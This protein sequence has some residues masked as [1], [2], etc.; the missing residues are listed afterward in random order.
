MT[1]EQPF[2]DQPK[3][4]FCEP[5]ASVSMAAIFKTLKRRRRQLEIVIMTSLVVLVAV[6]FLIPSTYTAT[7]SFIPPTSNNGGLSSL[8]NQL[9]AV[10]VSAALGA[11]K[12]NG[13][14]YVGILGSHI[15]A[16]RLV[17]RFSLM[18]V[19]DVKKESRAVKRL[20]S[21]SSFEV[22]VRDGIVTI[23]VTDRSATRARDLAN[24]YL[25]ELRRVTGQLALSE[26]AQRR[27]FFEQQLA[28]EK[29]N[30]A[31]AEVAMKKVQEK[32]GMVSPVGQTQVGLAT[33]AQTRA[34][35]SS[36][37]VQLAG[38]RFSATD[39]DPRVL[40]LRDEIAELQGQLTMLQKGM[41]KSNSVDIPESKVP[42]VELE[43]VR[44][45]REV[46]YHEA[47]FQM[48]SKQYEAARL[49]ESHDPPVLQVLDLATVPDTRSGP[50]RTMIIGIGFILSLLLG[51]LSILFYDRSWMPHIE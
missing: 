43:F 3:D 8:A 38:L 15:I 40:E 13:D 26:A 42:Q 12:N 25:E 39:Q 35:I 27:L 48:I 22:G 46:K 47:L 20:S 1:D 17:S 50:Q 14:L 6:A 49:D 51:I 11:V 44:Q 10:G 16:S 34:A 41:G 28:R 18:A 19:Y 2:A 23:N 45:E 24:G 21:K 9:S 30:L 31:D 4:V 36:R 37:Q 32:T 7:A 29:D 5:S 33:I